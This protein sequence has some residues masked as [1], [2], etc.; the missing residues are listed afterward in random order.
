MLKYVI[1]G[2]IAVILFLTSFASVSAADSKK[3]NKPPVVKIDVSKQVPPN[4]NQ[5]QIP[6]TTITAN[7]QSLDP[8]NR[9]HVSRSDPKPH[10]RIEGSKIVP[11]NFRPIESGTRT[12]T[13]TGHVP[14]KGQTTLDMYQKSGVSRGI[15]E[16]RIQQ[17]PNNFRNSGLNWGDTRMRSEI[18][19]ASPSKPPPIG[20][21]PN[22]Q[23]GQ[24]YPAVQNRPTKPTEQMRNFQNTQRA[25]R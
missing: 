17:N 25:R 19:A 7:P 16:Q 12:R 18:R 23:P 2:L 9:I 8:M 22:P 10:L 15:T 3:Q 4:L 20:P 5:R 24:R 11:S 6:G 21:N 14:Y 13:E 1:V